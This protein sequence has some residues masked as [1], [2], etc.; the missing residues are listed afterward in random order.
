MSRNHYWA[1]IAF[2]GLSLSHFIPPALAESAL[3]E[4]VEIKLV[5]QL[6]DK[7]ALKLDESSCP[8]FNEL[9]D[10]AQ[11]DAASDTQGSSIIT[12]V[13][14]DVKTNPKLRTI[15]ITK[16]GEPLL[17]RTLDCNLTP[18]RTLE[19]DLTNIEDINQLSDALS[20]LLDSSDCPAFNQILDE[21]QAGAETVS[22]DETLA[23]VNQILAD[24]KTNPAAQTVLITQLGDPLLS[25]IL[26]CNLVP[27]DALR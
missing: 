14:E 27:F 1:A 22:E 13:L 19:G 23:G 5:N 26:D 8:E 4:E 11:A 17:K 25:K 9:L 20:T 16:L 18:V 6:S 10:G 3:P 12:Q 7:L 2:F 24:A 15:V 21:A